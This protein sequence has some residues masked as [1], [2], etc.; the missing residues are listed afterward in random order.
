MERW[1]LAAWYGGPSRSLLQRLFTF[2][3]R[4]LSNSTARV[5]RRRR[6][7]AALEGRTVGDPPVPVIV[8]GNL[9]VGGTGKTPLVAWLAQRLRA[10]GRRVGIVSRGHAAGEGADQGANKGKPRRVS[11]LADAAT[12]GD[13][14]AWLAGTTG[15]PVA[16]G[17]DRAAAAALIADEV[18]VVLSDDGLQHH[19]LARKLEV[20]VVDATREPLLGTGRCLPSGPLRE[21]PTFVG[22][23][24]VV[25]FNHGA[26][27]AAARARFQVPAW[28]ARAMH[29]HLGVRPG[30]VVNLATGE[31][32]ALASFAGQAVHAVA[33]IGHPERFFAGLAAAGVK[34]GRT[35][36]FPDH[37]AFTA[38]DLAFGDRLPVLMTAKDAVKCQ[39]FAA[40]NWW[41]V[42]ADVM[43]EGQDGDRLLRAVLAAAA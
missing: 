22:T 37:H 43:F 39:P 5:A 33:G 34:E 42:E 3:V 38:A 16:V 40:P 12:A 20:I 24:H 14:P 26:Q 4:P 35:H 28:A 1:L 31:S 9:T 15:C 27:D 7:R 41:R 29:I 32:R 18:D 17:H 6:A 2:L 10:R 25:V 19:R 36:A 8:I 11:G 21:L 30:V 23:G 13:E